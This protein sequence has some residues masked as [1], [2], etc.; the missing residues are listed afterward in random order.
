MSGFFCPP[1][2]TSLKAIRHINSP[3]PN[4]KTLKEEMLSKTAP[5]LVLADTLR[6]TNEMISSTLSDL[7]L[8]SN[9]NSYSKKFLSSP[10]EIIYFLIAEKT[11]GLSDFSDRICMIF[12]VCNK[13]FFYPFYTQKR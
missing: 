9:K 3:G 8:M 12:S 10:K 6:F 1:L 5:N 11:L 13:K 7:S 4:G 2:N